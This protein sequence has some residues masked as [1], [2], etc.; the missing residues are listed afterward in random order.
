MARRRSPGTIG[1]APHA[2]LVLEL[3]TMSLRAVAKKYG[4]AINAARYWRTQLGIPGPARP[5]P[6]APGLATQLLAWLRGTPGGAT[7]AEVAAM[8]DRTSAALYPTLVRLERHGL[9]CR[10]LEPLPDRCQSVARWHAVVPDPQGIPQST[11]S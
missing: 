5:P 8:F 2:Q 9:L 3:R 7:T 6:R 10:T 11:A 1:D 4:V